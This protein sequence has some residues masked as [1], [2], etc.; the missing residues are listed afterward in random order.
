MIF[1]T[2]VLFFSKIINFLLIL[3]S[4]RKY[5]FYYIEYFFFFFTKF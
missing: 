5:K 4:L 3:Y 2:I 1:T